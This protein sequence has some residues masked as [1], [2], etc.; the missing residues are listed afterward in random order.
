MTKEVMKYVVLQNVTVGD[1]AFDSSA[2]MET[3]AQ[4]LLHDL[5]DDK[6]MDRVDHDYQ[7]KRCYARENINDHCSHWES[8]RRF[9]NQK[10]KNV[11]HKECV[12]SCQV[13]YLVRVSSEQNF[14]Y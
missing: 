4:D 12:S 8:L 3:C 9:E 1:S 7:L 2:E 6:W 11:L 14:F 5:T 13:C 10:H